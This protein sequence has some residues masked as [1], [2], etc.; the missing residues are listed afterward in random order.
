MRPPL[1]RPWL[2]ALIALSMGACTTLPRGAGLQSEI[3]EASATTTDGTEIRD[4]MVAPVTRA[5]LPLYASWPEVDRQHYPWIERVNQPANRIIA[6]GDT[7][8]VSIFST[9]ESGLLTAAGE[10]STVL[11]DLRVS[12]GGSI[13]LPYVGSLRIAGMSPETARERIEERYLEVMP[14]VQVLLGFEEGQMNTVSLI[15]GVG[16]PGISPLPDTNFT[17]LNLIAL[18]GGVSTGLENPQIRL[19]RGSDIYGTSMGRLLDQPRL[20]TTLVGGDRV[21]VEEDDRFFLSLGAA[22]REAEFSFPR[23]QIT[24]LEAISLIGGLAET[25]AD[26]QG[27]LI[28]R[29]YP[30]T[31]VGPDGTLGPTHQRVVFTIDLTSADG[32]FSAR[33]FQIRSGDLVYATESPVVSAQ[34]IFGLIGAGFGLATQVAGVGG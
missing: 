3:L 17:V 15:A 10:R 30:A 26:P 16:A 23:D 4:F 33:Q 1:F 7:V 21:Y 25:R 12:S 28:L 5:L 2:F 22:G 27:I 8:T 31:A 29:E 18:G 19:Q 34:T 9:E 11:S 24:A 32:L 13:F 6:S 14:S 20:D